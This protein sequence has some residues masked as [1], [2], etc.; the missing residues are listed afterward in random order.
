LSAEVLVVGGGPSGATV[1]ALLAR[2]GEAVTLVERAAGPHDKVC[3]EFISGEAA[4]YIGRLGLD[5]GVATRD[6]GQGEESDDRN[7]K[8]PTIHV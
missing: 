3:G 5:L 6:R 1:A 7:D 2:A 8:L 4:G